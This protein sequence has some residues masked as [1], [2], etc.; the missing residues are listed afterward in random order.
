MRDI[1]WH[2]QLHLFTYPFYYIEYGIAQLGA[3]Q[4]WLQSMNSLDG[5][6]QNYAQAMKLGGKLPL[7]SLFKAAELTFSFGP[8]TVKEL[9]DAVQTRLS[10]LP[11]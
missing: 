10:E 3:L 11:A 6:L 4:I 2:R 7:P 8:E 5:A 1:G 9:I